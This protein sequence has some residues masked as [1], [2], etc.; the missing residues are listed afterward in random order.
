MKSVYLYYYMYIYIRASEFLVWIYIKSIN[1]ISMNSIIYLSF[2]M[3]KS[4][5]TDLIGL[6]C[7]MLFH[8]V[9][10]LADVILP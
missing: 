6:F 5:P 8:S 3:H 10:F 2:S 4:S 1:W 9:R 7:D